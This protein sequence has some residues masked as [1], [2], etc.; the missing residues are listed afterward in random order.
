MNVFRKHLTSKWW[1]YLNPE[2][3]SNLDVLELTVFFFIPWIL[4]MLF[5]V[6]PLYN[7]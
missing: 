2:G 5:I 3:V 4:F 7:S 1:T 6:R